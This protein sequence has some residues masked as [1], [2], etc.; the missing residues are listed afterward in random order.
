MKRLLHILCGAIATFVLAWPASAQE[1]PSELL[2]PQAQLKRLDT[3]SRRVYVQLT[4]AALPQ[5]L[6]FYLAK[7]DQHWH[8]DFPGDLEMHAWVAAL[9]KSQEPPNFMLGLSHRKT[10]VNVNLTLGAVPSTSP[11]RGQTII[12]L[13]VSSRTFGQGG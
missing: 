9:E 1:L 10:K 12:T 4:K 13:Y 11:Y 7:T 5:V 6:A 2:Y 3:G 8:L